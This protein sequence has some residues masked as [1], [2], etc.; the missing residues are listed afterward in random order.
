MSSSV[1]SLLDTDAGAMR[2]LQNQLSYMQHASLV[3]SDSASQ[4]SQFACDY[5][6][7]ISFS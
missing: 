2:G 1:I 7:E 5:G 6:S 3:A 4:C